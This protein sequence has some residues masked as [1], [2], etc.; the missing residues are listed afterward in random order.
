MLNILRS[1]AALFDQ[2]FLILRKYISKELMIMA[3]LSVG[4]TI[5]H[6]VFSEPIL[7]ILGWVY[8]L[9]PQLPRFVWFVFFIVPELYCLRFLSNKVLHSILAKAFAELPD[10][11]LLYRQDDMKLAFPI[12]LIVTLVCIGLCTM[13]HSLLPNF[14]LQ[15]IAYGLILILYWILLRSILIMVHIGMLV[16]VPLMMLFDKSFTFLYQHAKQFI[17]IFV[18]QDIMMAILII[19]FVIPFNYFIEWMLSTINP[20]LNVHDLLKIIFTILTLLQPIIL[21]AMLLQVI[22]GIVKNLYYLQ[23]YKQSHAVDIQERIQALQ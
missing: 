2:A 10:E 1:S 8:F 13:L 21:C 16:N 5:F 17:G 11:M 23:V 7:L 4:F 15:A 18:M 20:G 12:A 6:I 9:S 19:L 3:V 22:D 14:Y